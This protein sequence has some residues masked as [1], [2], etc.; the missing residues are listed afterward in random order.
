MDVRKAAMLAVGLWCSAS[1]WPAL[2]QN[3]GAAASEV[4][5]VLVT[6]RKVAE[7]P[8]TVPIA[9]TA[10]SQ[11]DLDKLHVGSAADLQTITPSFTLQPSTFRQDTLD[12]T[13]RGQRNFDSPQ[14]G[15]NPSLDFDTA[16]AVYQDGVY[17][18][19]PIGL[20]AQ[21]FDMDSVAILKGPQGTLV[22]RNATGGA[23]L[24]TTRQPTNAFGGYLQATGGD[25]NLYGLQGALNVP[26]GSTLSARASISADGRDGYLK[27]YFFNPATG[28]ANTTAPMGYRRLAA[29]F[30]LKWAPAS[31]LDVMLRLDYNEEHDTGTSYHDLGYFVG[32]Q[33]ASGGRPSVCNIIFACSTYVDLLGQSIAPYYTNVT[34]HGVGPVNTAPGAYNSLLSSV[35]RAQHEGF[36]SVEQEQ[37]NPDNDRFLTSSFSVDKRFNSH[38]ELKF[39]E[40]YRWL[41]SNGTAASRGQ[42]F[43]SS[44]FLYNASD[45]QSWQSELTLL[46]N[47]LD[48]R[49][50]WTAGAFY[51]SESDP[52]DG[53]QQVL[54][55]TSST[56]APSPSKQISITTDARNGERNASYAGYAQATY[57]VLPDTRITAGVRYTLDQRQAFLATE[58]ILTPSTPAAA[59]GIVN[60]VYNPA[61]YT[62]E[63]TTY[64]GQTDVCALTDTDGVSLPL[65]QCGVNIARS[66]R[67]TTW[68]LA[69]DHDLFDKTM[70]YFTARTGY[71]SGAINSGSLSPQ[72]TV[73]KPENVTDYEVG[74][75]SDWRLFD[76][77]IRS[78]VDAYLTQYQDLQVQE[79]LP[80]VTL[81][82]GPGGGPCTQAEFNLNQCISPTNATGPVTLNAAAARV[83]G[84]EWDF[85]ALPI[86]ALKLEASGSYLDAV[87]TN[88]TFKPPAGYLLPAGS[89]GNL[90]GTPVPSP[91]WQLNG[92]A[93]YTVPP[94]HLG[95]LDIGGL[96]FTAHY[97]WQS[98]FLADMQGFNAS[99]TMAP[100]GMLKL[101]LDIPDFGRRNAELSFFV[102]NATDTKAC[103][104]EFNGTL[105]SLPVSTYGTPGASGVTQCIPL[106]P[107]MFGTSL[108]YKF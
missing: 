76:M 49:F 22:G 97:Y 8:Q 104:P 42:P 6:A 62:I 85:T 13:M 47:A 83:R 52:G 26:L 2:A 35:L 25:Y 15:G 40:A 95:S 100:Y 23:L 17:Y 102:D 55:T 10:L 18:A 21:L 11:A 57:A 30:Q 68:T 96:I 29:R 37:T 105:N 7:N 33:P 99:Q 69:V 77:P 73:A 14:G 45:Y 16:T 65:S 66:F 50:K 27:N 38:L 64:H 92:S 91:R 108:H 1:A 56:A 75:K 86:Q 79:T 60:G 63:G 31:D 71:R 5:T 34:S 36:W 90:S 94:L 32:T 93:T 51:F 4:E 24:L 58:K 89:G 72:V 88:F 74:L 9:I 106:P 28:Q 80:N 41:D 78:N 46:G 44:I 103:V 61:S 19:R 48:G 67:K 82:T 81:A 12:I 84:V 59:A 20:N 43:I 101:R 107:R 87:Y 53:A 3:A 70:V 54:Y 39:L 98:Q